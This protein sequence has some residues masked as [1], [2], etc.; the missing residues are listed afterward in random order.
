MRVM[1]MA[2]APWGQALGD[3]A[4]HWRD[5]RLA[6]VRLGCGHRVPS[7]T[8]AYPCVPA[9]WTL[10]TRRSLVQSKYAHPGKARGLGHVMRHALRRSS[11]LTGPLARRVGDEL[12]ALVRQAAPRRGASATARALLRRT[13]RARRETLALSTRCQRTSVERCRPGPTPGYDSAQPCGFVGSRRAASTPC[14]VSHAGGPW[15]NP[16]CAHPPEARAAKPFA[17]TSAAVCGNSFSARGAYGSVSFSRAPR[18]AASQ[19]LQREPAPRLR[20]PRRRH[21]PGRLRLGRAGHEKQ[22]SSS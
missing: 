9:R 4:G 8:R 16:K 2:G 22:G 14:V 17:C 18:I 7:D 1:A 21:A 19:A 20:L 6:A 5:E 13:R 10:H 15:F 11:A 3:T 12:R